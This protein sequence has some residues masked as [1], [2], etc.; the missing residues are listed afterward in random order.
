MALGFSRSDVSVFATALLRLLSCP[1]ASSEETR[2]GRKYQ[3]RG[4]LEGPS[5][6]RARVVSVWIVLDEEDVP[7]LV[8][9]FPEG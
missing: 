9:V 3:V 7:R 5:G 8:T 1:V 6:R 2:Y 4:W